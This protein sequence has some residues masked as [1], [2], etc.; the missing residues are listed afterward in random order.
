MTDIARKK[1][2]RLVDGNIFAELQSK[3]VDW[4][5]DPARLSQPSLERATEQNARADVAGTTFLAWFRY[6]TPLD[7]FVSPIDNFVCRMFGP[8]RAEYGSDPDESSNKGAEFFTMGGVAY[9]G[10][11]MERLL[12]WA[13]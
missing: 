11:R 10:W 4:V 3:V 12:W 1:A 8:W 6:V 13:T 5:F 2:T 9:F 7:S